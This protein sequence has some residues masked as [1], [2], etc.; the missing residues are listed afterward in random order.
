MSY[1]FGKDGTALPAV[2]VGFYDGGATATIGGLAGTIGSGSTTSVRGL[3]ARL[4]PDASGPTYLDVAYDRAPASTTAAARRGAGLVP[5]AR[6]IDEALQH[7]RRLRRAVAAATRRRGRALLA[8]RAAS[9]F[10]VRLVTRPWLTLLQQQAHE[11]EL[12]LHAAESELA[13]C[14][15]AVRAELEPA[16]RAAFARLEA[17]FDRL[18]AGT[19]RCVPPTLA[20]GEPQRRGRRWAKLATARLDRGP[21]EPV[22]ATGLRLGDAGGRDLHLLPG[23][24]LLSRPDGGL[25]PLEPGA[26]TVDVTAPP[27]GVD[28][29]L[30]VWRGPEGVVAA[31]L[32]HD[33]AAAQAFA[34]AY[35]AYRRELDRLAARDRAAVA[36]VPAPEPPSEPAEAMR[37]LSIVPP[38][39]ELRLPWYPLGDVAALAAVAVAAALVMNPSLPAGLLRADLPAAARLPTGQAEAAL[40]AVTA[41]AATPAGAVPGPAAAP[42]MPTTAVVRVDAANIRA[43]PRADAAVVGR[44]RR[45]DS[46]AVLAQNDAWVQVGEGEPI[47]WIRADL[48]ELD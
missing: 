20:E 14:V 34:A 15:V 27:P 41:D 44:A 18:A 32:A 23:L 3:L 35:D 6:V 4:Q 12:Q 5:L 16:A 8:L 39:T 7:R 28:G 45:G 43:E 37:G 22:A 11:A 24:A 47:G 48:I 40:P 10:V 46:L 13:R 33:T 36:A 25:A 9:L 2:Q 29:A 21:V 26:L 42:A 30:L 38:R 31:Q 1:Q 17:G 19:V